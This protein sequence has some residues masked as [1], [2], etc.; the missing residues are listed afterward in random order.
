MLP[1]D[2]LG[3]VFLEFDHGLDMINFSE[4]SSRCYQ[5]FHQILEVVVKKPSLFYDRNVYTRL[6]STQ[7]IHGLDLEWEKGIL[8]GKT[9]YV[10]H[11]KH[12][13]Q[14]TWH[15]SRYVPLY[16]MHDLNWFHGVRH[17]R[18]RSWNSSEIE[19]DHMFHYGK[20][21]EK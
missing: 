9:N 16:L 15:M 21:I 14:L 7:Q 13:R 2:L 4:I 11:H 8:T 18:S 5:V 20:Q 3:V 12:G 1:K 10:R 19:Y 17:G 6:R